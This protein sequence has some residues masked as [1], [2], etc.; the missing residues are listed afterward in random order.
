MKN[1][2][3]VRAV[4]MIVKDTRKFLMPSHFK[5]CHQSYWG[6]MTW[7]SGE[8]FVGWN[9]LNI[10]IVEVWNIMK[11]T[12]LHLLRASMAVIN[13]FYYWRSGTI[14]LTC[15]WMVL[16][17][18]RSLWLGGSCNQRKV[19]R[20]DY[21]LHFVVIL[22]T[23]LLTI[24]LCS[25][26]GFDE[27]SKVLQICRILPMQCH[28]ITCGAYRLSKSWNHPLKLTL[29]PFYQPKILIN[30]FDYII[31]TLAV[32]DVIIQLTGIKQNY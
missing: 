4:C 23:A 9:A 8:L 25:S 32:V 19:F 2:I 3:P 31:H 22:I 1:T 15:L 17:L 20:K 30:Q 21:L 29:F 16:R 7:Y 13:L 10:D 11:T 28:I 27:C 24:D 26:Q 5:V 18:S 12:L 14:Y 6:G